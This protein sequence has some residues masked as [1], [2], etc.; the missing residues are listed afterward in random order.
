MATIYRTNGTTESVTPENGT[1]F[2]LRELQLIVGGYIEILN[3]RGGK[4]MVIN[5]EGKLDGLQQNR[6]ATKLLYVS[7]PYSNDFIV[8]DVLVCDDDEV[9]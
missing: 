3:L 2:E 7:Y 9:K 1:D 5:E 4:I 8:G 6:L